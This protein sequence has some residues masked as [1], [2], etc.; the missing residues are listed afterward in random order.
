MRDSVKSY[1]LAFSERFEGRVDWL[2]LDVHRLVTVGVGC[3]VDSIADV[4][5]LDFYR[6]GTAVHASQSEIMTAWRRVKNDQTLDPK[7]GGVQY[8][9]LTGIRI[10]PSSMQNLVESKL[11]WTES[12]LRLHFPAWDTLC[13]D[14]QLAV[15][16]KAWAGGGGFADEW[17]HLAAAINAGDWL[18]AAKECVPSPEK[19]KAQN[20]SYHK[21]IA[22]EVTLFTNAHVVTAQKIDPAPL[23]YPLSLAA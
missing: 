2:Y 17:P 7:D 18:T 19:M 1:F 11:A 4:Q 22:A 14:A 12:T 8:A 16:S 21:R 9:R 13:A 3:L 5:R 10:T 15:M 20:D 6:T 23:Q